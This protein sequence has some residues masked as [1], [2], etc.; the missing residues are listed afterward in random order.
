MTHQRSSKVLGF[1][2]VGDG[3]KRRTLACKRSVKA[4]LYLHGERSHRPSGSGSKKTSEC[5]NGLRC[6]M[7]PKN[8][9]VCSKATKVV[10]SP[11]LTRLQS[12]LSTMPITTGIE[13]ADSRGASAIL[14][15]G[16]RTSLKE[17]I[18]TVADPVRTSS[19]ISQAETSW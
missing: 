10:L 14:D 13:S 3:G 15:S 8:M 1:A 19:C 2:V 6:V 12:S 16:P 4:R 18:L 5:P 9:P 17:G 7:L 11:E